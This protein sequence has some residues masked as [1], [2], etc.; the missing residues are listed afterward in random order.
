MSLAYKIWIIERILR[1]AKCR[2]CK[3]SSR[4]IKAPQNHWWCIIW[5]KFVTQSSNCAYYHR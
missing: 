3:H 4:G 1:R 2:K 5:N